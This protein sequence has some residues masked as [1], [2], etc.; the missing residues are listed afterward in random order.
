MS[1]Y[2]SIFKENWLG[3]LNKNDGKLRTYAQFKNCLQYENYLNEI[4]IGTHRRALT[5]LRTSS[6]SLQIE[7]GRYTRPKMAV[8]DRK[9]TCSEVVED[10][11]HFLTECKLYTKEREILFNK[12]TSLCPQFTKLDSYNKFTF[13]VT[14]EREIACATGEFCYLA[15]EIRKTLQA[16]PGSS[17]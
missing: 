5:R 1:K 3:I 4:H 16:S 15:F 9:C 11:C 13:L 10:E 6:H 8:E 14:A 12:V 2:K 17:Q 7:T